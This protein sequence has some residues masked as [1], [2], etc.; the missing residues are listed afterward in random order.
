M[1]IYRCETP[2]YLRN[3]GITRHALRKLTNV[4]EGHLA[5]GASEVAPSREVE[6]QVTHFGRRD[7]RWAA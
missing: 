1:Y 7:L 4:A 5:K 2:Y 3:C 6:S